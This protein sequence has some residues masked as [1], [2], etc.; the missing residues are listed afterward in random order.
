[1]PFLL[2]L[3]PLSVVLIQSLSVESLLAFHVND[4]IPEKG[5]NLGVGEQLYELLVCHN[6]A[7]S[8]QV[9]PEK[10]LI[11]LAEDNTL[12]VILKPVLQ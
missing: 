1:M 11:L 4:I 7:Q 8:Y 6:L 10:E 3:L 9:E 5:S 2:L 12:R